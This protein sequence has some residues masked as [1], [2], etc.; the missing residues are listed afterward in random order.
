MRTAN[1][2]TENIANS[3]I[4]PKAASI[5]PSA[6]TSTPRRQSSITQWFRS[7][8]EPNAITTSQQISSD[9]F[10]DQEVTDLLADVARSPMPTDC[11][12]ADPRPRTSAP[13]SPEEKFETPP[14]TPPNA[15]SV[16]LVTDAPGS[17]FPASYYKK[18]EIPISTR[19]R[20]FPESMKPPMPRKM[21]RDTRS[22]DASNSIG[23]LQPINKPVQ[24]IQRGTVPYFL[25][26]NATHFTSSSNTDRSSENLA[27][28]STSFTSV[29]TPWT[30]PN[31]SFN[32][33]SLATSFSSDTGGT[34]ST[35]RASFG[36][37]RA[38]L[39]GKLALQSEANET[40]WDGFDRVQ[41]LPIT[42]TGCDPMDIDLETNTASRTLGKD[43]LQS[44]ESLRG[45]GLEAAESDFK[46]QLTER[47]HLY[48]PFCN[49]PSQF[50]AY[51]LTL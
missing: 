50:Y 4:G 20:S 10:P 18:P 30:S 31:T 23:H 9:D 33:E 26:E 36:M 15:R 7:K 6:K 43:S 3:T 38:S 14:S 13:A 41:G 40:A 2:T 8:S 1:Y 44:K 39:N 42:D 21:S 11:A 16:D 25:P 12:L 48:S 34:D 24:Q 46:S 37:S 17:E 19:K 28:M 22:H 45:V 49:K 27:S 32:S 29:S 47:L 51:T 35:I 5:T